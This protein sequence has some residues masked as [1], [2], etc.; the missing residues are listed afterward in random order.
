[1][2]PTTERELRTVLVVDDDQD[3]LEATELLL[4]SEGYRVLTARDGREALERLAQGPRPAVILLDLMMP[5]MNGF[6]FYER[7]R[8]LG[9]PEARLPVIVISA[10]REAGRHARE[11]GAE[12]C[13]AKPYELQDLLDKI[14]R[15][16]NE[17]SPRA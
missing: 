9:G 1:M 14:A 16:L 3:I 4:Q 15:Q 11:L 17:Q 7:L 10:T 13:L 5:G 8:R 6:E 12:D 2:K